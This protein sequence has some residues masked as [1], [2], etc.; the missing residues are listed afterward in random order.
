MAKLRFEDQ[1]LPVQ[2]GESV[3][4]TLLRSGTQVPHSCHRGLCHTCVLISPDPV[5]EHARESLTPLQRQQGA[6][7]ACCCYPEGDLRIHRPDTNGRQ[8]ARVTGKRLLNNNVVELS[9]EVR[10][11]WRAGQNIILWRHKN[12]G[13]PYSIASDPARD[14][15]I[16]LHIKRHAFGEVSRWVFDQVK[17]GDFLEVGT[18]EGHFYYDTDYSDAPLLLVGNGT[19][20]APLFGILQ[21]ALQ[22]NHSGRIDLYAAAAKSDELYLVEELRK[23][24]ATYPQFRYHPVVTSGEALLEEGKQQDD[25]ASLIR[26]RH[27]ELRQTLIYLCGSA[28]MIEAVSKTCFFNGAKRS[29]IMTDAF[30]SQESASSHSP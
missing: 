18:P 3:L 9:L 6:F 23:L 2:P 16:K 29:H 26:D 20:L 1:C 27:R 15:L 25:L 7:L 14:G 19:G 17:Q 5:P 12:L 13:R 30:V 11:R 4:Q 8:Q 22:N 10:C 24:R 21:D 28:S